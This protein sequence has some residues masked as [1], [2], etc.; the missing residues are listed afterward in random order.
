MPD[1]SKGKIYKLTCEGTDLAYVGS[2]TSKLNIRFSD[3][4]SKYK[5]YLKGISKAT[6]SFDLF[7]RGKVTIHLI[8]EYPCETRK[9]LEKREGYWI[10]KLRKRGFDVVNRNA[11]GLNI[12]VLRCEDPTTYTR[13][14][15]RI[16]YSNNREKWNA[17]LR[18]YRAKKKS[19]RENIK[20]N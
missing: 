18:E 9:E 10:E 17:Y 20:S 1:Y 2:T 13:E 11:A 8:E 7:E 3:H 16:Y 12:S 15:Q 14:K 19:E 5:R 4:K 6:S